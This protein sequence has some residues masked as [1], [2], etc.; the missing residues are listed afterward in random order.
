[1]VSTILALAGEGKM[2]HTL[3]SLTL[4]GM[5][6]KISFSLAIKRGVIYATA[7]SPLLS[8]TETAKKSNEER[9]K[10]R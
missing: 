3:S 5:M 2:G 7:S 10:G 6:G 4:G 9:R 1:M 8:S